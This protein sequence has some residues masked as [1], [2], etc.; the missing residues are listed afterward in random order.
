MLEV[1]R[2]FEKDEETHACQIW[3]KVQNVSSMVQPPCVESSHY[4]DHVLRIND[5]HEQISG[6]HDTSDRK[7]C[8][9]TTDQSCN[10]IAATSID[11]PVGLSLVV[12]QK[13]NIVFPN[14]GLFNLW[15]SKGICIL[16]E[17]LILGT[18]SIAH[19]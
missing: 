9:S 6:D 4:F 18:A 5:K 13:V 1:I 15:A 10:L 17:G 7:N 11:A 16:F 2:V 12:N 14:S 8:D 3:G 19:E